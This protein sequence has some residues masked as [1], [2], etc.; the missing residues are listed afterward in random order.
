MKRTFLDYVEDI[1]DGMQKAQRFVEGMDW[2]AFANDEKT[3]FATVRALEIIGEAT[4]QVPEEVRVR[5]PDIPW[6]EMAGMRDRV[7]HA[8]FGVDLEVVWKTVAVDI[9][10]VVRAIQSALEVLEAEHE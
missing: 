8:Y 1:L 4:K 5:F 3:T 6:R 10:Q 9:P 2:G 7:I